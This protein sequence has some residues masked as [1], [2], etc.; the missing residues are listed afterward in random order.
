MFRYAK[1]K[2]ENDEMAARLKVIDLL[3][4]A[5]ETE[6]GA[7]VLPRDMQILKLAESIRDECNT[8]GGN[9]EY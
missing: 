8:T 5:I 1:L 3:A 2:K 7:P 4:Y 6:I 9:N